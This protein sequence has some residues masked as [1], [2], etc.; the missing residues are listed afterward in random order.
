VCVATY[1][2]ISSFK[3]QIEYAVAAGLQMR[4]KKPLGTGTKIENR[5]PEM[6]WA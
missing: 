3:E 2:S 1:S 4:W 6:Q 5:N